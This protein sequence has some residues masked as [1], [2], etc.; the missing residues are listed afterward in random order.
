LP[1]LP[2]PR[3]SIAFLA[4]LWVL[5]P[6]A[7]RAQSAPS[8]QPQDTREGIIIAQQTDK[9]AHPP[10]ETRTKPE[11]VLD[12]VGKFLTPKPRGFFPVFDS[13]YSGGGL[14]LGGGYGWAY[15][16][17][18]MFAVRGLYSI[19]NY[20]LFD[21]FTTSP[22]HMNGHLTLFATAGWR[23]ATDAAFYGLGMKTSL[24]DRTD[25]DLKETYARGNAELRPNDWSVFKGS[26]GLE[27]YVMGPSAGSDRST[28][29]SLTPDQAPGVGAD[30]TY[31]HSSATAGIDTRESPGYSRT[32]GYYAAAIHNYTNTNGPYDFNRVDGEAIQ[33][34]PIL[35]ETWVLS[36]RGR[37]ESTLGDDTGDTPYFLLPSLGS[38]S[39]LRGYSSWRF[40]DR[41]SL[42]TQGEFRWI[43]NRLGMDMAVFY[44][45]GKVAPRFDDLSFK[46]MAHDWGV[47]VRFHGPSFTPLRIELARGSEGL[48]LVFSGNAAF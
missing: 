48:N 32:G 15:G 1:T 37:V 6:A 43:P 44:D 31:I 30:P 9:A 18:S 45:A 5:G 47:G 11:I 29:G 12:Y 41:H 10:P 27:A 46:G 4:A 36:F 38:G 28:E 19:K 7:A 3:I 21:V 13:V 14:T 22:G 26:V 25:S 23:N 40:R 2:T 17:K 20:K 33:H 24:S 35:R 42:L 8:A 16:D 34:I 39:T